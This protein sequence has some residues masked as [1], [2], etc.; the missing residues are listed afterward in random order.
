MRLASDGAG[1]YFEI[2]YDDGSVDFV[3]YNWI[4]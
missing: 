2:I 3:A 4:A 1:T